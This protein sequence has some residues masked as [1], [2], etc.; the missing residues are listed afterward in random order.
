M[1]SLCAEALNMKA[2]FLDDGKQTCTFSFLFKVRIFRFRFTASF[3]I[4]NL[5]L[6]KLNLLVSLPYLQDVKSLLFPTFSFNFYFLFMASA[7]LSVVN[8]NLINETVFLKSYLLR[9]VY[10]QT[11]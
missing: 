11:C 10:L 1:T 9:R 4:L 5:A 2:K 8:Q 3:W 6:C 7:I